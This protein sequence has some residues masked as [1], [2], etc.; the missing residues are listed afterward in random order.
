MGQLRPAG[1]RD[2]D[3]EVREGTLRPGPPQKNDRGR[4]HA[5][6]A[7]PDGWDAPFRRYFVC[8][9]ILAMALKT[10]CALLLSL[11]ALATLPS[12]AAQAQ[13]RSRA[14]IQNN[15][16][17]QST[18]MDAL[19]QYYSNN[20]SMAGV[21]TLYNR[22]MGITQSS[23]FVGRE[24]LPD[25]RPGETRCVDIPENALNRN[26]T[27]IRIWWRQSSSASFSPG[28]MEE[29]GGD[30]MALNGQSPHFIVEYSGGGGG[31]MY[32]TCRRLR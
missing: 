12:G 3:L 11:A 31:G 29:C 15:I 21:D 22:I 23:E 7:P 8:R 9:G 25:V 14:C 17:Y 6:P 30:A 24:E 18:M 10:G 26:V 13:S 1:Q 2:T 16:Q 28:G 5:T 32:L 27:G 20:Q 4:H 19:V